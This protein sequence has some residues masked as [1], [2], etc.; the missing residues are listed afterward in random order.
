MIMECLS[1]V[2]RHLLQVNTI[3]VTIST[4]L[5]P[6]YTSN[7][8]NEKQVLSLPLSSLLSLSSSPSSRLSFS[9]LLPVCSINSTINTITRYHII[10]SFSSSSYSSCSSTYS[11]QHCHPL[12]IVSRDEKE[13]SSQESHYSLFNFSYLR[14]E[15]WHLKDV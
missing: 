11:L 10:T 15:F 14:N 3:F 4:P 8:E 7:G 5:P 13:N 1:G 6:H 2:I 12:S 9:V